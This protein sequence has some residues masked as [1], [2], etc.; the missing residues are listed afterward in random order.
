M[1][2]LRVGPDRDHQVDVGA[3]T[4]ERQRGVVEEQL[5]EALAAGATLYARSSAPPRG[6]FLPM[7]VLTDVD[8]RMRVMREETFGPVLAVMSV[9]TMDQAVELANDSD[10]GLSASVWSRD[11][12]AAARL[13]RRIRAGAVTLND[14]LLSHGLA[15]TPW[16]GFRCSGIGR[17]HGALGFA[18]MTEPQCIVYDLVPWHRGSIWWHPH[19]PEVYRGLE[20]IVDALYA[21]GPVRR[22]RGLLRMLRLLPRIFRPDAGT[23]RS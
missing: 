4:T 19:G 1:R 10:L 8:H 23:A 5:A 13:A 2:A 16:G 15:E 18:E 12:R 3:M 17:T 20:G 22:A 21:R 6:R 7:M 9:D 11:Q 14:H